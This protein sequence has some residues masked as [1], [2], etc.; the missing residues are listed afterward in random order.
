MKVGIFIWFKGGLDVDSEE[1]KD[2]GL[3]D[4]LNVDAKRGTDN[5]LGDG[6]NVGNL[7]RT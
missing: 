6:L 7:C 3:C 5:G 4:G 2:N 1:G